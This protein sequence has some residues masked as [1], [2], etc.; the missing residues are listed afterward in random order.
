MIRKIFALLACML[1]VGANLLAQHK[2]DS[3]PAGKVTSTADCSDLS[4]HS[5]LIDLNK[6][7]E[8]QKFKMVYFTSGNIPSKNFMSVRLECKAG[9][10]YEI[11]YIIAPNA[12]KY[13]LNVI[14]NNVSHIVKV[15]GKINS[16]G[17]AVVSE[18]FVAKSDGVYVIIYSQQT[19]LDNCV[20]LSVFKK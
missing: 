16:D 1:F 2:T 13:Q 14:D 17:K 7:L 8:A 19:K 15:K 10:Q 6:D 11:R 3:L 4:V 5:L 12:S 18:R 20:G 9:E